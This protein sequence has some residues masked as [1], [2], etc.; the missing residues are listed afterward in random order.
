[1][2][3]ESLKLG[4][5]WDEEFSGWT[6]ELLLGRK[7]KQARQGPKA[8][9]SS[10]TG[11]ALDKPPP[12]EYPGKGSK[13]DVRARL[14]AMAKGGRQVMIKITGGSKN[15]KAM[16]RHMDYLSREGELELTDQDGNPVKG[17]DALNDIAWAWEHTGPKMDEAADRKEAFNIVF[18]MPEGTDPRALA[19]AVRATA[20][21]EFAGHQWVMVQHFDEPQVH[22]HVAVKAE[23]LNGRRLN[24]RKADLQRWRER[25]AYEL[26]ER[27]VEAEATRRAPR[28]RQ[29]KINKPWAVTR[30]EERGQATNPR[31]APDPVKVQASATSFAETLTTHGKVVDALTRSSDANDQV[32]ARELRQM[33]A[34]QSKTRAPELVRK[35]PVLER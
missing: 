10:W 34:E 35:A 32:L 30:L 8:S 27:G 25:F 22:A 14:F 15:V 2:A 3:T 21:V 28:M 16:K 23:A 31:P 1:M 24:P 6:E 29:A 13:A 26:R 4:R 17:E 7:L 5:A 9:T 12:A 18:S 33:I 11:T 20:G 19:D